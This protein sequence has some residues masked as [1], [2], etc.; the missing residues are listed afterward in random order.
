MAIS[1]S[2]KAI[3]GGRAIA[4]ELD[5]L[6][7]AA[8]RGNRTAFAQL[9]DRIAGA[10]Y[11]TILRVLRDP[12]MAEEVAQDVLLEVWQKAPNYER[13]L[14]K[15]SSWVLV[16]AHRRAID[17]VRSE[18]ARRNRDAQAGRANLEVPFDSTADATINQQE[19]S[20]VRQNLGNL[21][22]A[23]RAV[24][25]LAY[26][27]GHT[28]REVAEMLDLPLG[29]VKTRMRSGLNRLRESMSGDDDD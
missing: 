6:L 29:T 7:L 23:E 15:A 17:R 12:S 8:G 13:S 9:Y 21:T 16:T 19:S 5:D 24:I 4:A 28:Y 3:Y 1:V 10:V 2:S 22:D 14:G 18:Q 26:F 11:G 27:G 20:Q 25:A